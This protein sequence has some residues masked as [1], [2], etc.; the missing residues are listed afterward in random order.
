M[1]ITK[2]E[3]ITLINERYSTMEGQLNTMMSD[4]TVE[5]DELELLRLVAG[6]H[7]CANAKIWVEANL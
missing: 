6:L 1:A 4:G 5:A 2:T 7:R 3:I